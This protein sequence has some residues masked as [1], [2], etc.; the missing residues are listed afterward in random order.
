MK[1]EAFWVGGI[2]RWGLLV[3]AGSCGWRFWVGP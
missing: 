2:V 3:S 1:I